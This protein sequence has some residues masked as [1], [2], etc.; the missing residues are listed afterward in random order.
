LLL[1]WNARRVDRIELNKNAGE[2]I[3]DQDEEYVNT[4]GVMTGAQ[5]TL[6]DRIH[7]AILTTLGFRIMGRIIPTFVV[8]III[9]VVVDINLEEDVDSAEAFQVPM[10]MGRD[11]IM[12]ITAEEIS[13]RIMAEHL[14]I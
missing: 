8:A 10:E 7:R 13:I 6:T 11:V 12:A 2:T 5:L 3:K 9:T 1:S 4:V 14:I